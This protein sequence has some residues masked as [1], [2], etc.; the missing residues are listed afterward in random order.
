MSVIAKL[1]DGKTII[2]GLDECNIERLRA[3]KPFHTH[4]RACGVDS[5]IEIVIIL[6][7]DKEAIIAQFKGGI[8]PETN[9][10]DRSMR[11]KH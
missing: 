11:P 3:G 10:D 8:T 5:D 6:G 9:F 4:L 7:K 1:T 2:I